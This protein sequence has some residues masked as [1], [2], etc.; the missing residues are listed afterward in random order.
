[1]EPLIFKKRDNM[2]ALERY[3]KY[4]IFPYLL[5]IH[6]M[7]AIFSTVEIVVILQGVTTYARTQER[8]IL[9]T[10]I[11][12]SRK[13]GIDFNRK[14]YL[15]TINELKDHVRLTFAK[16]NSLNKETLEYIYYPDKS[17]NL[18]FTY[19]DS[20]LHRSNITTNSKQRFHYKINNTNLGPFEESN[21]KLKSFLNNVLE[22]KI[23]FTLKTHIPYF[24]NENYEC[25]IWE[26]SQ[27]YSFYTRAHF[28]V[29]VH[30]NK[31]ICGDFVK[32]ITMTEHFMDSL[33]FVHI[34]VL[35]LAIISFYNTSSYLSQVGS[36]YLRIKNKHVY[37]L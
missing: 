25:Y 28:I 24:Y 17:S 14:T 9:N 33:E 2:S 6:V 21:S 19:I 11:D 1:M 29:K 4:D 26:I 5:I 3:Q 12:T 32:H 20:N 35:I 23:N 18:E 27:I 37:M 34:L 36:F 22:F 30:I 16:Y 10:F 15:Y 7:I 13:E 31:K 8:L